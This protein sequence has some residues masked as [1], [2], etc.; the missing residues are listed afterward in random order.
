MKIK[1]RRYYLYGLLRIFYVFTSLLPI[2][3][4][5]YIGVLCGRIG[6]YLSTKERDRTIKHLKRAFPEKSYDEIYILAKKVFENIVRCFAEFS[7]AWK[8]TTKNKELWFIDDGMDK[9]KEC[10]KMGK[11][12]IILMGH[13]GNWEFFGQYFPLMDVKA[14]TIV[15]DLYFYKY[16]DWITQL[17]KTK[18]LILV[19][20][21]ETPRQLLE[22]LKKNIALGILADQD[23]ESIEGIFVD[24]FKKK[25]YTPIAPVRLSMVSKAPI[26]PCFMVR[27]GKRYRFITEDPIIVPREKDKDIVIRKYTEKWSAIVEKY[28]TKYPD[29]W[30][31]M[32]RRW[33]TRPDIES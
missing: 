33:K 10:L 6:F 14:S 9:V 22:I 19:D 15:K 4:I 17:R 30:V 7:Q 25:A 2:R 24:F 12:C 21:R 18:G 13:L 23:I 26:V 1:A 16:N 3:V 27:E 5:S 32:H 8:I 20:R 11:G 29:Q 28:I 31:W